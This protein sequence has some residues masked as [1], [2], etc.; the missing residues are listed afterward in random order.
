MR[1]FNPHY[2]TGQLVA[3]AAAAASVAI[4]AN[5]KTVMLTNLGANVCYVR[6]SNSSTIAAT[7]ADC[8]ILAGSQVTISKGEEGSFLSHISAAGTSL[9]IITGEG[10]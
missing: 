4:P 6:I 3:P 8:P 1:T 7:T 2:A 5:D 10:F 9:H